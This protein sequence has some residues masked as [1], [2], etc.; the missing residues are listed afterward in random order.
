ML[1]PSRAF[2]FLNRE[3]MLIQLL[4]IS[5]ASLKCN[6]D[7]EAQL[8]ANLLALCHAIFSASRVYRR[9]S[10]ITGKPEVTAK[11]RQRL[12]KTSHTSPHY[13]LPT[14]ETGQVM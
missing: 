9:N 1:V 5:A 8:L 3:P 11:I 2:F 6:P 13:S 10:R 14:P 12:P 4:I 7:R